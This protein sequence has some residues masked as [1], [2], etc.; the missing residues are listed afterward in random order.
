MAMLITLQECKD[1]LG[2]ADASQDV[3]L[4]TQINVISEAIENY[5]GRKFVEAAYTETYYREDVDKLRNFSSAWLYHYPTIAV[6]SILGDGVDISDNTRVYKTRGL[7]KKSDYS[8]HHYDEV[9]FQY[10]AGYP[11]I[12]ANTTGVPYTIKDVVFNLVQERY[13]KSNAGIPLNFGNNV[14]RMSIPGTI[15]IDFDYTLS[16]NDRKNSFGMI[17]G[18]YGNVIDHF[19]SE[20]SIVGTIAETIVE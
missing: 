3:F 16:T 2:I 18:D 17:L 12:D 15:S 11:D 19:R 5:T 8:F 7:I 9:E 13:N 4:T 10:T 20:R 1:F 14:Q 6:T